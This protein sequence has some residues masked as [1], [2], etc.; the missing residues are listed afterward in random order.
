MT[1]VTLVGAGGKMGVRLT[2][3]LIASPYD[4]SYL[5]VSP[6]GIE[7]VKQNGVSV[8]SADEA[9]PDADIVIFAVPDVLIGKIVACTYQK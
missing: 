9:I 6:E 4:V 1:K 8:S 5:E 7:R 3:N 2:R